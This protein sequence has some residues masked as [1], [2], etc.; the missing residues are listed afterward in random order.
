MNYNLFRQITTTIVFC[1]TIISLS[2]S[3][4]AQQL[5][6]IYFIYDASGSM[7]GQMEGKTKMKV[8]TEVLTQSV[9][10]LAEGQDIGLVA[11]GHRQKGDC[12]DVEFVVGLPNKDK[13]KVVQALERIKPL[14]KTPLAHSALLVI[15]EL[16]KNQQ[17][18]TII[19]ITDGIESCGGNI[20]DVVTAA[21]K[22]GIDFKLHIVG[23]GLKED[24]TDQL[25]CAT[26]AGDGQYYDA[27]NASGLQDVL[28]KATDNS[29]DNRQYNFSLYAT[30]GGSPI[31]AH[32]RADRIEST[33]T[34]SSAS[35]TFSDT[36]FLYL[37]P[38]KYEITIKPLAG[39]A[40]TPVTLEYKCNSEDEMGH[41][42][43]SF[44]GGSLSITVLSNDE[45]CDAMVYVNEKK[46]G[47][48]ITTKR[49]YSKKTVTT[50]LTPGN[51]DVE[52]KM[53][54]AKGD[55]IEHKIEDVEIQAGQLNEIAHNFKT[56]TLIVHATNNQEDWDATIRVYSKETKNQAVQGR[57]IGEKSFVLTPGVYDVLLKAL[58][59]VG[60]NQTYRIEQV[61]VKQGESTTAKHNFE[62]GT[63]R[64]SSVKDGADQKSRVYIYS[65]GVRKEVFRRA[66]SSEPT[67]ITL[68]PGSY[69]L[70]A[71][72]I[73]PKPQLNKTTH[74]TIKTGEIT[75]HII[76]F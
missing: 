25:K 24:E 49:T 23:F 32:V 68:P 8:A 1:V 64:L 67:L 27:Q 44:D 69:E 9:T 39:S 41:K 57:S 61:E 7:W 4:G 42:T 72:A 59:P 35:R 60:A 56:G 51:Y 53:L 63:L 66:I 21:K 33:E 70:S 34:Y 76:S 22:E 29:V 74:V 75:E 65:D 2:T 28:K 18:A 13:N 37:H 73:G 11:Y 30:K 58:F 45:P 62:S 14:G 6:P 48:R 3:L 16:R 43:V 5:S 40:I 19:L 55:D 17:K 54:S 15:D 38:G 47:K 10:D 26:E 46:S 52:I 12:Q 36:A 50:E 20:C 31:D 71:Q